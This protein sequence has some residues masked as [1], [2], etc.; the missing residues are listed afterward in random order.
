MARKSLR[1]NYL[2]PKQAEM[3]YN[4]TLA[5]GE[6]NVVLDNGDTQAFNLGTL[7]SMKVMRYRRFNQ[8]P[9]TNVDPAPIATSITISTDYAVKLRFNDGSEYDVAM[10]EVDNQVTWVNSQTGANACVTAIQAALN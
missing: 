8:V 1:T 10:G 9:V 2:C 5:T 4:I 3:P 7:D 6:M